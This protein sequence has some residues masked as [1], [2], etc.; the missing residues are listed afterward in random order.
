VNVAAGDTD[1]DHR[2]DIAVAP[3][4]GGNA[5]VQL[6]RAADTVALQAFA[7]GFGGGVRLG[8]S[9]GVLRAGAGPGGGPHVRGFSGIGL[10]EVSSAFAFD[11]AF[12]G[13]VWVG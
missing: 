10:T 13:G 11:P 9:S 1:G 8:I 6:V 4:V 7:P 3:A 12:T 5:A 2:A